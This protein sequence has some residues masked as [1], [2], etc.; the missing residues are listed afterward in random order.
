MR[1]ICNALIRKAGDTLSGARVFDLV[2]REATAAAV[3]EL[4]KVVDVC[5][6]FK[7]AFFECR[8]HAAVECPHNPWDMP[9]A[10]LFG[11]L[12]AC[13]R[14]ISRALFAGVASIHCTHASAR[15]I[16]FPRADLQAFVTVC[17]SLPLTA[18][19]LIAAPT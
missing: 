11:R 6:R 19:F 4:T 8:E 10:L 18:G 3:L 14:N 9:E 5:G 1:E 17:F 12:D 2:R 16:D 13:V 7:D 15:D